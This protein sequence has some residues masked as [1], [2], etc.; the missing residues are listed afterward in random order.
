VAIN[1][2]ASQAT[3]QANTSARA[4][5]NKRLLRLVSWEVSDES[6]KEAVNEVG[7]SNPIGFKRTPGAKMITLE[8]RQTKTAQPDID[9]DYLAE[10][11]EVISL[12]KQ[13]RGG[14][15]TQYPE[16]QVSKVDYTGDNEGEITYT[17]EC[18]ALRQVAM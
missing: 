11:D 3:W 14:R 4:G 6:S 8:F 9:W 15:R 17:V 2:I 1:D 7:S 18:I 10:S 13:V 12:T 5:G 16:V